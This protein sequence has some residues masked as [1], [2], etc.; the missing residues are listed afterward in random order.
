M[1]YFFSSSPTNDRIRQ[2]EDNYDLTKREGGLEWRGISV[3][4]THKGASDSCEKK[5]GSNQPKV[6]IKES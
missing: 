3:T 2:V 4:R 6:M 1:P 5:R